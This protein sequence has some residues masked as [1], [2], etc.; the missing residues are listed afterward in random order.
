MNKLKKF[1]FY[2][3][4]IILVIID[5]ITKFAITKNLDNLP[6]II[7]KDVLKFSYCENT[8]VAFSMGDGN[9]VIF[10]ILNI[11]LISGL[12]FYYEKNKTDFSVSTKICISG[13]IAGGFS[14][15]LDRIFRGFVV[16]FIDINQLF[17]FPIFNVADIFIVIGILGIC[18]FYIAEVWHVK[19]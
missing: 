13:V 6:S 16:D 18:C 1:S 15:L 12:I 7:I 10:I 3:I 8:G 17:R 4:I 2:Y 14:N 9:I 19:Q 11:I 5:Q